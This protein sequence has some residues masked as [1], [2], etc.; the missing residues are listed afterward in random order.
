MH[1]IGSEIIFLRNISSTNTF[2]AEL[3]RKGNVSEGTIVCTDYQSAGRGQPGNRWHSAKG[4]NLLFTVILF[5]R[6]EAGEQF[7]LSM[8]VSEGIC[9]FLKKYIPAPQ[10]KW[11]NDIYSGNRKIAGILIENSIQGNTIEHSV[12]GIGLNINQIR[13]PK[14][15]PNPVS[16]S[17]ITGE[18]YDTGKCLREIALNL[19]EKYRMLQAG[20][21]KRIYEEYISLLYRYGEWHYYRDNT[22]IFRG[23]IVSVKT[24]GLLEIK[25]ED[26]LFYQ[27]S[28]REVDYLQ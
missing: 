28:F 26:G 27:Y 7:L 13:F 5:P 20:D 2:A 6:I 10:I 8:A 4:K 9:S 22:G 21:K 18:K 19:D 3:V 12:V 24:S 23:I 16:M 17:L 11:P 14:T 1:Q 25:K 15:I